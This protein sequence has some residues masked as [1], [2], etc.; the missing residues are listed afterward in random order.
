M[1]FKKIYTTIDAHVAGEPL[2]II[3][4]GVPDIKGDKQLEK[5]T[6]CMENLDYIRRELM[7]EPRGHDGMYGCIITPPVTEG[8]AFG[9]LF[10]HNE[11]WSTMCGHGVIAVVTAAV[12]TGMIAVDDKSP[13]LIIDCPCGPVKAHARIDGQKVASVA[14]ENVASFLYEKSFPLDIEG[15][16]F[17]VDISYG[18][19]FYVLVDVHDL[20]LALDL[21]ALPA[22]E[23]WGEKV[24]R[25][26]EAQL[27]VRHPN[28]DIAGI[29]GTIFH[30]PFKGTDVPSRN[31]T[32]FGNRQIDRSPCGSGTAAR[33][34][35]LHESGMLGAG[36]CFIHEGITGGK[37]MTHVLQKTE[38]GGTPAIIPQVEGSAF[39]TGHH[40]FIID[41]EDDL[42]AGF[43]LK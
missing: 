41:P 43:L 33:A 9:A 5:R 1:E 21:Q 7:H 35:A 24:K 40:Q 30:D 14:F 37:F 23:K 16:R 4:G 26:V 29:Y 15:Y 3:T 31:V 36:E 34:A 19:A 39:I 6:Y 25:S 27:E 17:K 32:V 20:D 18:G 13:E 12:E 28:E 10:M 22:L 42:K 38:V 11:G 2:R 8:A